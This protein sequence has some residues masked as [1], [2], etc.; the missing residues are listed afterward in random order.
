MSFLAWTVK[1][2]S[3]NPENYHFYYIPTQFGPKFCSK[4]SKQKISIPQFSFKL[5]TKIKYLLCTPMLWLQNWS[6][7]LKM[8]FSCDF[9]T[10]EFQS[11]AILNKCIIPTKY[12]LNLNLG[13]SKNFF[14]ILTEFIMQNARKLNDGLTTCIGFCFLHVGQT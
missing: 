9:R 6:K 14:T 5:I 13:I 4:T 11:Y 12:T 7:N 2:L 8:I 1:N 10:N 3:K